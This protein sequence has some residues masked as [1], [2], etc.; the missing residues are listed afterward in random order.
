MT[1][2]IMLNGETSSIEGDSP[3]DA[4]NRA[5]LIPQ[6]KVCS[7]NRYVGVLTDGRRYAIATRSRSKLLHFENPEQRRK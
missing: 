1:F 3:E 2:T 5:G 6:T 4:M 7:H